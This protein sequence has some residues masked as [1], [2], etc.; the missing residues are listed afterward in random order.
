VK[1]VAQSILM[2]KLAVHVVGWV[3]VAAVVATGFWCFQMFDSASPAPVEPRSAITTAQPRTVVP[4]RVGIILSRTTADTLGP[5]KAPRGY[6]KQIRIAADLNVADIDIFPI[7]EAG[8]DRDPRVAGGLRHYFPRHG[9]IAGE[10]ADA[11]KHLDVIANAEVWSTTPEL[12]SAVD[13]AVQSGVGLFNF[14][15]LGDGRPGIGEPDS[16]MRHLSGLPDLRFGVTFDAVDCQVLSNHPILGHLFSVRGLRLRPMGVYG[17]LPPGATG[18]VGVTNMDVF[19][20]RFL[21]PNAHAANVF[22]PVFISSDGRGKIVS[23]NFAVYG[24]VPLSLRGSGR[25]QFFNRSIHW[26]A[27][28]PMQ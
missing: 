25:A 15:G 22:Y 20:D 21:A 1:G 23:C 4:I 11:L 14:Y 18:L 8:T 26:L 2:Q 12:L 3:A 5:D 13:A 27:G 6:D 10:D 9:P 24:D 16:A 19:H 17:P 28:R 7:V